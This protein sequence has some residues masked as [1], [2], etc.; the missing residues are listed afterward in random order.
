MK[1]QSMC[2]YQGLVLTLLLALTGAPYVMAD[3]TDQPW[4]GVYRE[5]HD[6][7]TRYEL[8]EDGR[9]ALTMMGQ[10][11]FAGRYELD[12]T[13]ITI[14]YDWAFGKKRDKEKVLQGEFNA[15]FSELTVTKDAA[16]NH[17]EGKI[18]HR[19]AA[20]APKQETVKGKPW[21]GTFRGKDAI[22]SRMKA[23]YAKQN[24]DTSGLYPLVHLDSAG[25]VGYWLLNDE[26]AR[27]HYQYDP[28]TRQ[29]IIQITE[30][31]TGRKNTKQSDPE[32]AKF[33]EDFKTLTMQRKRSDSELYRRIN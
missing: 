17:T 24:K 10:D 27:G 1:I 32:T 33:S 19:L 26:I 6:R 3:V 11:F 2:N 14:I 29:L 30:E 25:N 16:G 12:G 8:Y 5:D 21:V 22:D 7:T 18:H 15:D 9:L 13:H 23:D 20:A 4:V 28:A 31:F